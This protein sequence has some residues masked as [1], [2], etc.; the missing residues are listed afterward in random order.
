MERMNLIALMKNA[1]DFVWSLQ[2]FGMFRLYLSDRTRLHV[3]DTRYTTKDVSMIHDH[4]W[5]F[6]SEVLFGEIRDIAY[7]EAP[8]NDY[9]AQDIKCGPSGGKIGEPRPCDLT[10]Y[11]DRIYKAGETYGHGYLTLHQSQP[12]CGAVTLVT[13]KRLLDIDPDKATVVHRADEEWV[14]A[15]PVVAPAYKVAD[16]ARM[17]LDRL[18]DE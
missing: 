16:M 9:L 14:S 10:V 2:G 8:G 4:P 13:R 15:E 12:Q 6:T 7:I 3:W 17:V 11:M 5:D 1:T 18:M